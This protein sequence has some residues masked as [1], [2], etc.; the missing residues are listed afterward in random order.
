ME[1]F[2][3]ISSVQKAIEIMKLL[4][5][6]P[7][8]FTAIE[9]S[10]ALGINR[11]TV[12]RILN[13]LK[14]EMIILQN[15]STKK[16]KIGPMAYNIGASYLNSEMYMDEIHSILDEVAEKTRLSAGYAI[17]EG[18]K[19]VNI[20][21]IETYIPMRM[22]YRP[23]LFYPIHCGVYGKTIMAFYSPPEKLREIVHSTKLEKMTENT[24]TDPERL[25]EEYA[26]IREQGYAVSDEERLKGAIGIGAPVRNSKGEVV[27]CI[28]VAGIKASLSREDI[29]YIKDIVINGANRI[30][31]LI[32]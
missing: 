7:Y 10:K 20:Y 11:S 4:T 18:D 5:K 14:E 3:S 8:T 24:I 29:E 15:S 30:S 6:E 1:K 22:G 21:E 9:I 13:I 19:I 27:A 26:K 16:Y 2:S 25:L 17:R 32:P 23:G 12:H 28:G 31:R